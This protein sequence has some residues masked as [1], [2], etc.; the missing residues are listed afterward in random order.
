MLVVATSARLIDATDLDSGF[1]RH[2]RYNLAR[3]QDFLYL[4]V[5]GSHT[6]L[7]HSL[8]FTALHASVS[9]AGQH[10]GSLCFKITGWLSVTTRTHF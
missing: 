6:I 4:F 5:S 2:Q 8:C 9:R 10:C 7:S 1:I 3:Q